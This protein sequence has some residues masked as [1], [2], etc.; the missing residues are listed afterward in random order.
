MLIDQAR[1]R[2]LIPHAGAMCL[3]DRVEAWSD[4]HIRCLTRSHLRADNP[5]REAGRLGAICGVE[6][7]AQAMALHGALLAPPGA[8]PRAGLLVSL[9]D[10]ACYAVD[11]TSSSEELVVEAERVLGNDTQV[12]YAFAVRAGGHLLLDGRATVVLAAEPAARPAGAQNGEPSER[13][14]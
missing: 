10:T 7:A 5:L 9:R 3:L 11:L 12:I 6:Y 8:R 14:G 13:S 1:I 4:A 2:E